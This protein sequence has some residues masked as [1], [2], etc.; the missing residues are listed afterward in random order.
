MSRPISQMIFFCFCQNFEIPIQLINEKEMQLKL[1]IRP[2]TNRDYAKITE[3]NDLAFEQQN[4][5]ILITKLRKSKN[6]IRE[7]SLVAE[8]GCEII[9]HIL[10]YPIKINSDSSTYK[11]LA[12]APMAVHP[13]YQN[14]GIG[15][16]LV[17]EGLKLA[18]KQNFKS[19]IVVGHPEYYPRFG[20]VPASKWNIKAPFEVPDNAFMA[21]ELIK[22]ELSNKSG[23]VEYSEE[24]NEV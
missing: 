10:F 21:L 1:I 20:F 18:K 14:K 15:S 3:I 23:V 8:V 22:N 2:E 16:N 12:L 24:F 11:S 7:L 9:G 5:G 13:F 19:V 4:E 17:N 6:Y